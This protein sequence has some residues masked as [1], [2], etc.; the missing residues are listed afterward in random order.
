M[1]LTGSPY[2]N[3][4]LK[5]TS[6]LTA[7]GNTNTA[8]L[9]TPSLTSA[10]NI[11]YFI[12]VRGDRNP[13]N[14]NVNRMNNTTL[15]SRGQLQTGD[16]T[17]TAS[18]TA[19]G[20]TLIGNPFAAPVDFAKLG[21]NNIADKMWLWDPYL[22]IEQGA[23]VTVLGDGAGNYAYA[24]ERPGGMTHILQSG[25][26]F[27]VQTISSNP[28]S[29][30][31]EEKDK[32]TTPTN[33]TYFRPTGINQALRANLYS[34]EGD[35]SNSL[36]DGI[37]VQFDDRYNKS[38]DGMDGL[39]LGNVKEMLAIRQANRSLS[40]ERRPT[41]GTADTIYLRLTKTTHRKYRF[42]FVPADLDPMLTAFIEDSYKRTKT[43]LSLSGKSVH[44]FE[45]NKD[46][47]SAAADRFRIVFKLV[48]PPPPPFTYTS[49]MA[50]QKG[51][52]IA[53]D[54]TVKNEKGIA[55]YDVE[56]STDGTNYIVVHSVT[57][58]RSDLPL[59]TYNWVDQQV[60]TGNN[61]YR[62][63][64]TDDSG[65][66]IYSKSVLVHIQ[67]GSGGMRVYPN[68]VTTGTI[69][70]E[71]KNMEGGVYQTRLL[72]VAG[73]VILSKTVNH[74]P[75]TSME[76]IKADYKLAAGLYNLEVKGPDKMISVIK[77]IVK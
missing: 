10:A 46:S 45:V 36:L 53:V 74:A 15:S 73:Q 63:R 67:Q 13:V 66:H 41:L 33:L 34:V 21:K 38:V 14:T 77:V 51:G 43:S 37:Y 3:S 54:W 24:P 7:V 29:L 65:K 64:N 49:V 60:L 75:G 18:S 70:V 20:F 6:S 30:V 32:S 26:A 56:K 47:A 39:K 22:N 2:N 12:F 44:D 5:V 1:V 17:F 71:F 27:F 31:F 58:S 16:Q 61:Y 4:S 72:N 69:G 9:S 11:G 68:P 76:Y 23:Y 35:T 55:G 48:P 59:A 25:Q 40:I 19:D 62:I 57:A 42:E 52:T 50:S 8:Y 28:A